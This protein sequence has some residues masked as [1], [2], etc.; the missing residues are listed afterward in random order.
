MEDYNQPPAALGPAKT[1]EDLRKLMIA[2]NVRHRKRFHYF[3]MVEGKKGWYCWFEIK[4]NDRKA[5]DGN[6]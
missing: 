5:V 4:E 2:N 3:N 6:K 1:P